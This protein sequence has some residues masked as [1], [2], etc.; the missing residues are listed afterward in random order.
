MG[1]SHNRPHT[2]M[3]RFALVRS[4]ESIMFNRVVLPKALGL[5]FPNLLELE[6]QPEAVNWEVGLWP[7]DISQLSAIPNLR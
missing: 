7:E 6:L 3:K 5:L 4:G 2:A 1:R